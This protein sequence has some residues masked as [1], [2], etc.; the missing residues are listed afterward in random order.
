MVIEG[1]GLTTII[2][3]FASILPDASV[4]CTVKVEVPAVVAAPEM[5]PVDVLR[6]RPV[7]K[8]PAVIAH[9]NGVEALVVAARV[10]E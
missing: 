5:T 4:T 3:S 6:F 10:A 7:G 1:A 8:L 2:R 9:V